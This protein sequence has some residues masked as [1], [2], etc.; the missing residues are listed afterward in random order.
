MPIAYP[1]I[2]VSHDDSKK[3]GLSPEVQFERC[4]AYWK[5]RLEPQGIPLFE[6]ERLYDDA[7]SAYKLQLRRRKAGRR[8]MELLQRGDHVLLA[9]VDRAFR[10]L[11]DY[12]TTARLWQSMGVVIHFLDSGTDYS[13]PEG[14]L[15][16][17][18]LAVVAEWQSR[19]LSERGK[20]IAA[21]LRK[22]GRPTN[23]AKPFG[24]MFDKKTGCWVADEEEMALLAEIARLRDE[25]G[26]SF[27]RIS[28]AICRDIH[29]CGPRCNEMMPRYK[30]PWY[31]QK[32][33]R[34]YYR[35][36]EMLEGK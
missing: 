6:S 23:G 3:S 22:C 7:V 18:I 31:K 16:A 34:A 20:E 15:I 21:H 26:L 33:A 28:K 17:N 1:Y 5:Y 10:D 2:R 13:T 12:T 36:K 8:L 30:P 35:W 11:H 19:Q 14:Q 24:Y 25:E 27:E 9:R 4:K 29:E 32:T